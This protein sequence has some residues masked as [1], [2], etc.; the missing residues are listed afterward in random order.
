MDGPMKEVV[1]STLNKMKHFSGTKKL[2][3]LYIVSWR[4]QRDGSKKIVSVA[5]SHEQPIISFSF[6]LPNHTGQSNAGAT[7]LPPPRPKVQTLPTHFMIATDHVSSQITM[8]HMHA[9]GPSI[10][11]GGGVDAPRTQGRPGA[12]DGALLRPSRFHNL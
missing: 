2:A 9:A 11:G 8:Q 7:Y 3:K 12:K 5:R 10:H 1:L 4:G 6:P